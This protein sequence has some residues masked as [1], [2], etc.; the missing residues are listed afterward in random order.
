M[1]HI[2]PRNFLPEI[3]GG[4]AGA[5]DVANM[6]VLEDFGEVVWDGIFD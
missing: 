4:F 1:V 5:D 3:E 6:A 2:G